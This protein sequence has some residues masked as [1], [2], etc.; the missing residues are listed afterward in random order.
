MESNYSLL[1][2]GEREA[3]TVADAVLESNTRRSTASLTGPKI[4]AQ[5]TLRPSADVYVVPTILEHVCLGTSGSRPVR[6]FLRA[7]IAELGL[8]EIKETSQIPGFLGAAGLRTVEKAGY[9]DLCGEGGSTYV[10]QAVVRTQ[11]VVDQ[12]VFGPVSLPRLQLAREAPCRRHSRQKEQDRRSLPFS[13]H[14]VVVDQFILNPAVGD[15]LDS[16][17]PL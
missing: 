5:Y 14:F 11:A 8:I 2:A 7:V 1:A 12:Q 3:G 15:D 13:E 9:D 10:E 6:Q 16:L 4:S 17:Q